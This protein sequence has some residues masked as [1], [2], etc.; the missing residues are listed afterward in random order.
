MLGRRLSGSALVVMN[1]ADEWE[2]AA[3]ILAFWFT[4][5]C[6]YLASVASLSH[7]E[8]LEIYSVFDYFFSWLVSRN[9]SASLLL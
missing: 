6:I 7:V 2:G 1:G 9:R 8:L 3:V 4:V 5:T